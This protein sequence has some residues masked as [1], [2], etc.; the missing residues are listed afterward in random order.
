MVKTMQKQ[1]EVVL[2]LV[3]LRHGDELHAMQ[4]EL[5]KVFHRSGM[6]NAPNKLTQEGEKGLL[7]FFFFGDDV[8]IEF[9]EELSKAVLEEKYYNV[10]YQ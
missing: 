3:N 7:Q 9:I 5:S 8:D 2:S 10:S 4:S 1:Y 6:K